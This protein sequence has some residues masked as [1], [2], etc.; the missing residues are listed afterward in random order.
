[1]TETVLMLRASETGLLDPKELESSKRGLTP[2]Q[3]ALVPPCV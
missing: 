2:E 3:Y 1:M